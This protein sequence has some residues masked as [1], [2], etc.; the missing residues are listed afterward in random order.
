MSQERLDFERL[1]LD[2][3][4]PVGEPSPPAGRP[5]PRGPERPPRP[6]VPAAAH[7]AFVAAVVLADLAAIAAGVLAA[8]H[9]RYDT[10]VVAFL[11]TRSGTG[12]AFLLLTA[13][14]WVA[15]LSGRA[16]YAPP[17]LV[18]G[19]RQFL[20]VAG[21]SVVAWLAMLLL[22]LWIK[23]PVP[24]ESRLV[25]A[26]SLPACLALLLLERL[27][28][29][30]PAARRIYA[31]LCRGAVL[32]LADAERSS[33]ILRRLQEEGEGALVIAQPLG[34]LEGRNVR[35]LIEERAFREV[36]IAPD[37]E[38]PAE[39]LTVAFQCLDAGASV[40]LVAPDFRGL[41]RAL[42]ND[43]PEMQ[44]RR[45]DLDGPERILKRAIDLGGAAVGV[46]LL[47]PLLLA[48]AAAI[49]LTSHGPAIFRQERI[50]LRG[51]PFRMY[52]FRTMEHGNDAGDYE[53][54]VK[55]FILEGRAAEVTEDGVE[56]FKP[57]TDPR[58]TRVGRWLRRLSLD[59]LPQLWNVLKGDMSLVGPR[60]CLPYEWELYQPW[61]RRRFDVIPGCT[62][63]WQVAGRS[64]VRFDDMVILDLY[65]AHHGTVLTDLRL[66]A[67]T[68]PVMLF[69]H[70]AY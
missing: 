40:R 23:V 14:V 60:P 17:T 21:A 20:R 5:V 19:T 52:K 47:A 10:S 32:I 35:G 24:F 66:I 63:L 51:R 7:V 16:A 58:V 65:Y 33:R 15:V 8:A 42:G 56:I 22:A 26:V 3:R 70:G 27:L 6:I 37:A 57:K 55:S 31:R 44:L 67:Q 38:T 48:I 2:R 41:A 39:V 11:L 34:R 64:R 12:P 69:G 59:E 18:S 9:F 53:A 29:V 54:Y 36:I 49:R 68:G 30:R 4:S 62:G 61:Q 1:R 28:L 45:F 43:L 13:I 50:G 46:V 25:M